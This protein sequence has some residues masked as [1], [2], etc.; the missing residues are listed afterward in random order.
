MKIPDGKAFRISAALVALLVAAIF[1]GTLNGGIAQSGGNI[2]TA[3]V[4][5]T[6]VDGT[7]RAPYVGTVVFRGD[8]IEA[9]G[10]NVTLPGDARV[11]DAAGKTLLPGIFDLHTHLPY[12]A[13]PGVSGDWPKNLKAYLYCGVTSVVDFGTYPETFEP[14][15]RLIES[16]TVIGPR[17]SLA[18]RMTTPGGHGAEGGRGDLFSLEVSTAG[19]ARAAVRSV[20]PYRPDVI[21]VFTDGWRY[22]AAPD[23]TSM[24]QETLSA[25]VDEAHKHGLEVLTHTVTLD[26]AKIAAIAGVDVIAH[27]IGNAEADESLM[28]LM[29]SKGVAYA[30]T[31]AVY[32]PRGRDILSPLL[33]A[34]LEPSVRGRIRPELTAEGGGT[35]SNGRTSE[36]RQLRWKYLQHNVAALSKGGVLFAAGTD[37]G[38][39]GTYHGWATLR[40]LQLLVAGG[41]TPL[42]ALTAATGN[43]ARAIKV[44]DQRGTLAP[45]KLADLLLIDGSPHIDINAISRI[46]RVFLGGREI[47]RAKLAADIASPEPTAIPAAAVGELIDD[48]ESPRSRLDT[49]WVNSTDPGVDHSTMLYG[50]VLRDK[51][52]HALSMVGR[53]SDKESPFIRAVLPLRRGGV[54]PADARRYR[55]IEFDVRGE[56]DYRLIIPTASIRDSKYF[57]SEFSATPGWKTLRIGFDGLKRIDGADGGSAWTG[58]D[59]LSIIFEASGNPGKYVWLEI[60]N[61]KFHK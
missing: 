49:L 60:D 26:K 4:G 58:S 41:L 32:E 53:L 38:V 35:T 45:G 51:D 52:N 10:E 1:S 14:M 37:A 22:G 12:A 30:P 3:I 11:I 28:Q 54:E 16:G 24:N 2:A 15:R 7:G 23:M 19:Q 56:G 55:G 8:R 39:S 59:L 21:K 27:G 13:A 31:L 5:A 33:S 42:Q 9:V 18:A 17:I 34:V 44:D 47:D 46:S 48:F 40:E 29:T 36:S 57:Q 50:R 43:A 25:L 61:L 20:L 6:I